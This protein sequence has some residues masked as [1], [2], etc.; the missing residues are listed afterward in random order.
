MLSFELHKHATSSLHA[1]HASLAKE[2]SECAVI[3]G[4]SSVEME[5]EMEMEMFV[6]ED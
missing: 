2:R 4:G 1:Q 6:K 3:R 5:M